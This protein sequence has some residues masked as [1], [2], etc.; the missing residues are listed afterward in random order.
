M[1]CIIIETSGSPHE[2]GLNCL[3]DTLNILDYSITIY[4]STKNLK[5]T[6]DLGIDKK[7]NKIIVENNLFSI[8]K[9]INEIKKYDKVVYHTIS[10]RNT[11][12]LY[13]LAILSGISP[14]LYIRNINSWYKY[15]YHY[16]K[17]KD[18]VV[19]NISILM[20][21][22]LLSISESILVENKRMQKTLI[23]M[24]EKCVDVIPFKIVTKINQNNINSKNRI[25]L[26]V[27]GVVDFKKKN[28]ETIINSFS[29]LNPDSIKKLQLIFL[30]KTKS[31]FEE[32]ICS[33]AQ[34]KFG[35]AF[36]FYNYFID[37]VEF[38]K[39]LDAASAIIGSYYPVHMCEHFNEVYGHTKG[40][41]VDAHAISRSIPLFVNDSFEPDEN[42]KNSTIVFKNSN[43]LTKL[44]ERI[45][46]EPNFL[47]DLKKKAIEE[48]EYFKTINIASRINNF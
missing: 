15:S 33:E 30:G 17:L 14:I 9:Y 43:D 11:F 1:T 28:L 38:E 47:S 45:V 10:V 7:I 34:L 31:K 40:S 12:Q 24:G 26:V 22:K 6:C 36:K 16:T 29:E 41:A 4:L 20:K 42:Y 21:K 2:D 13:S 8:Y 23:K 46:S 5:N 27:P 25:K 37:T 35:D 19:R 39:T 3:V 48:S 18:I 44:F 32:K